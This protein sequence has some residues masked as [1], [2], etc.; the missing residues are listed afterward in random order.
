MKP[1]LS[2]MVLSLLLGCATFQSR[3][4]SPS[5]AAAQ[6]EARTMESEGLRRFIGRNPGEP[7]SHWPPESWDLSILTLAAFYY[8]PD[9]DVARA[10]WEI[11]RAGVVTA[12]GRPNPS[13]SF[14]P[15][16]R[17]NLQSSGISPWTLGFVLDVPVETAGKRGYRIARASSLSEAARMEMAT[18][19]WRV[20]SRLRA[21]L[22]SLYGATQREKLL[23]LRAEAQEET[24]RLLEKRL[25]YGDVSQVDLTQSRIAL[26][27][28]RLAVR[29]AHGQIAQDR[30]RVAGALGVPPEA[31][32]GISLS[33]D[34]FEEL[35]PE[36]PAEEIRRWALLGRADILAA[37]ARYQASQSALQLEI[38]RQYPDFRLG[39]G[40]AWDQG[41]NR[42]TLGL[43]V[44]L[45]VFNR[46]QGPIAEAEARRKRSEAEFI[47]LQA[48]ALGSVGRAQAGY[49]KAKGELHAADAI[50]SEQ[51]EVEQ[52]T[53]AMFA[54]GEADRLALVGARLELYAAGLSRLNALI[55]AQEALGLLEDAVQR[56]L[57]RSR[58][59]PPVPE[60]NPR[61]E[62]QN[63]G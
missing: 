6:F 19:A 58:P 63:P 39:P 47:S 37:L 41:E 28:A 12:G 50:L 2:L 9:L 16:Y 14:I 59:L 10:G 32:E 29:A 33:F 61:A 15:E 46:N 5:K 35:P 60:T 43:S 1:A 44:S 23:G 31:L 51:R 7:P 4:L 45:P 18:A 26:D 27:R 36:I 62:R 22:L 55:A 11:A 40:Y 54:S 25:K 21:S 42:W 56:P 34:V 3:P 13:A 53:L 30:A 24:V 49:A 38:A 57:E 20:R 8:H 48:G 17:T 52:S